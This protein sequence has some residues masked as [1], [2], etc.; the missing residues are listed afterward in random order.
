[1][2]FLQN[3]KTKDFSKNHDQIQQ[4]SKLEKPIDA[5]KNKDIKDRIMT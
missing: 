3:E 5:K 2:I 1:M 4:I